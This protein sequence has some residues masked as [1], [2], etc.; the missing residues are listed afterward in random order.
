MRHQIKT[1]SP[2][3]KKLFTEASNQGVSL[4]TI[5]DLCSTYQHIISGYRTGRHEPG[6]L[7][8]E[9]MAA[10]IGY[11]LKLAPLDEDE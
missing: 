9:E 3:L 10:A 4:H 1:I 2:T 5:A 6:I 8:V 7:R 11:K